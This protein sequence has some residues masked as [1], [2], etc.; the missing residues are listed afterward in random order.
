MVTVV[1]ISGSGPRQPGAAMLVG[2]DGEVVGSLSGGCVESAAYELAQQARSTGARA[3]QSYGSDD[4]IFAV[5]PPCGGVI[6]VFAEPIDKH[7]FPHLDEVAADVRAGRSVAVATALDEG[8]APVRRLTVRPDETRGSLGDDRLD[9]AVRA[10]ALGMLAEGRSGVLRYGSDG[11]RCGDDVAVFVETCATRPRMIV[12]GAVDFSAALSRI[13]AF[14]GYAVTVCDARPMFATA[15]RFPAAADVVVAWPH[16][17]LAATALDER[18][19]VCV[20]THDPKFDLP[21]L[22]LALRMPLAYVGAM[23]SRQTHLAR[24]AELRKAGLTEAELARLHAPIGLDLGAGTPEETAVSIA[25][26]IL[27]V[28]RQTSGLPLRQLAGPIHRRE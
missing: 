8:A 18:T 23:G 13:G 25:A 14:L 6:D 7:T 4:D 11:E 16:R 12:V 5:A 22:E 21:V 24:L 19:V 9:S 15:R 27:A 3:L 2:P 20:L 1:G 26:E 10:D 17:Y 28:R